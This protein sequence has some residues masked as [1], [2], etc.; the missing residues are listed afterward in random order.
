MSQEGKLNV[1]SNIKLTCYSGHPLGVASQT[2]FCLLPGN[3]LPTVL[4][5]LDKNSSPKTAIT[6]FYIVGKRVHIRVEGELVVLWCYYMKEHN[7]IVKPTLH[8]TQH[9]IYFLFNHPTEQKRVLL[10]LYI[11]STKA[12]VIFTSVY[13]CRCTVHLFSC[14]NS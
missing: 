11:M 7:W 12:F 13:K 9:H 2:H 5:L 4:K 3:S 14:M 10:A 1:R 6:L 8:T